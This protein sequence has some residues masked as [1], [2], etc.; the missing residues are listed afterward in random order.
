MF[1]EKFL[2]AAATLFIFVAMG[3]WWRVIAIRR[4]ASAMWVEPLS[5]RIEISER[6]W[7]WHALGWLALALAAM[8]S[9]VDILVDD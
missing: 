9:F 2:D 8:F 3:A 4:E 7:F 5:D 1:S 6:E